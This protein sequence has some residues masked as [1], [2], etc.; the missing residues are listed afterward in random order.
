MK[1]EITVDNAPRAEAFWGSFFTRIPGQKEGRT[2]LHREMYSLGLFFR[3]LTRAKMLGFPHSVSKSE[4]PDFFVTDPNLGTFGLELSIATTQRHQ[5]RLR[6]YD[7]RNTTEL[8]RKKHAWRGND[9]ERECARSILHR[10]RKKRHKIDAYPV[11]PSRPTSVDLLLYIHM[12]TVV[13]LHEPELLMLLR[14]NYKPK[15]FGP[16]VQRVHVQTDS[17]MLFDVYGSAQILTTKPK[18]S[19][20][21][22]VGDPLNF[23]NT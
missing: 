6:G 17:T 22:R 9:A 12:D 7:R 3:L 16:R 13:V 18:A 19:K 1:L 11:D 4:R 21:K 5:R 14:Q 10:I 15:G 23:L 20:P 2:N 8:M